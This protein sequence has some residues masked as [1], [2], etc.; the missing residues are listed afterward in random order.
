MTAAQRTLDFDTPAPKRRRHLKV[1]TPPLT[2]DVATEQA[3]QALTDAGLKP[4][5]SRI[6]T[7]PVE[8]RP[9][10]LFTVTLLRVGADPGAVAG[11]LGGLPGAQV[12]RGDAA[13]A[14]WRR[15][16]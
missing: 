10:H 4:Q 7:W 11:V 13:V 3:R 15:V 14:V 8:D 1:A 2:P 6:L 9:G 5:V 12:W 16:T